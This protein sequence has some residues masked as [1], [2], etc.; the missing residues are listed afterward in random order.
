M[1]FYTKYNNKPK[2]KPMSAGQHFTK[3]FIEQID[4]HGN[5]Y[6]EI[7]SLVDVN[8]IIQADL[9]SCKIENILHAVEMGDMSMLLNRELT[10]ADTT[11]MP[12]SLADAQNLVLRM[13]HEFDELPADIRKEFNY[14]AEMYVNMMGTEEFNNKMAPYN[15]Q[16]KDIQD[17]GSLEAYKAKVAAQAKF[18]KDVA[19]AMEGGNE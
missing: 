11:N 19:A 3:K 17:A 15:K 8:A 14:S 13:K 9:E 7:A 10:Y 12:K 1:K 4:K 6:L 16:I 5:K 18:N 2:S